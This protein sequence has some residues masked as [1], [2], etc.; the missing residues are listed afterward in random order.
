[1]EPGSWLGLPGHARAEGG[2]P[3]LLN[4]STPRGLPTFWDAPGWGA[5]V[6]TWGPRCLEVREQP[7]RR[8]AHRW[9]SR[10]GERV[11]R[12]PKQHRGRGGRVCRALTRPA[13]GVG[14]AAL[15]WAPHGDQLNQNL[16]AWGQP[17][18]GEVLSLGAQSVPAFQ[19]QGPQAVKPQPEAI[20]APGGASPGGGQGGG[21]GGEAQAQVGR[22]SRDCKVKVETLLE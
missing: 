19:S 2:M 1:M 21:P 16:G 4:E 17:G 12:E 9:Q 7:S 5:Q 10:H 20:P 14:A 3:W 11:A 13:H 18:P 22:R 6:G 8:P 15:V